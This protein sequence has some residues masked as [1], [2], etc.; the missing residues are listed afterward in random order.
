[1]L[2]VLV[3]VQERRSSSSRGR[4]RLIKF[5]S[6]VS[7]DKVSRPKPWFESLPR[8]CTGWRRRWRTVAEWVSS[9]GTVL[10]L[11]RK[12]WKVLLYHQGL[13]FGYPCMHKY[14]GRFGYC[15]PRETRLM[16]TWTVKP[17]LNHI[18]NHIDYRWARS[19]LFPLNLLCNPGASALGAP[20][21]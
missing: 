16:P 10:R 17:I 11:R 3:V 14:Q 2:G 7:I 9:L 8:R 4:S 1:M 6:C 13:Y 21:R 15:F 19:G 18:T 5:C 20:H 12:A